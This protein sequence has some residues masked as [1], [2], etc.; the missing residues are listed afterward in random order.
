MTL[1]MIK[2]FPLAIVCIFILCLVFT[3]TSR[4]CHSSDIQELCDDLD[5]QIDIDIAP[6]ILNLRKVRKNSRRVVTVHTNINLYS[7]YIEPPLVSVWLSF[8]VIRSFF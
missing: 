7:V 8:N 4:Q 3:L 6:S 1:R 5:I 2:K